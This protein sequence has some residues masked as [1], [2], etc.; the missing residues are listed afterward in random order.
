MRTNLSLFGSQ[1]E[2]KSWQVLKRFHF[3][4]GSS[5]TVVPLEDGSV[6]VAFKRALW[7]KNHDQVRFVELREIWGR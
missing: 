6:G 2:G 7:S 1:D 3:G 5:P 4:S